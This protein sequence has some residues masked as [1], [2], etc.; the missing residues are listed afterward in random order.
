MEERDKKE[1][2]MTDL[3]SVIIQRG[4]E[5]RGRADDVGK[6]KRRRGTEEAGEEKEKDR[7]KAGEKKN[8]GRGCAREGVREII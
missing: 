2:E 7:E 8:I 6:G 4:D 1:K 5:R 3:S